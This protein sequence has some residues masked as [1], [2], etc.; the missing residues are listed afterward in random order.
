[1]NTFS[2][3]S[4]LVFA[5]ALAVCALGLP[6]VASAS[7]WGPVG[8]ADHVLNTPNFGFLSNFLGQPATSSCTSSSF[9]AVVLSAADMQ[10]RAGSF[11]GLCTFTGA[12]VGTCTMT[13]TPTRLPWTATAVTTSNIQIHGVHIDVRFEQP[14]NGL[15]SCAN[16]NG[17]DLTFTG[18]IT[19]VR[20]LGPGRIDLGGAHG[21]VSHSALGNNNPISAQGLLSDASATPI[22]VTG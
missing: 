14:R 8:G 20:Y 1:M 10:I 17:A 13:M 22:T 21:L 2:K 18:T 11:G 7:S 3:K 5:G 16:V 6:A 12:S 15:N 19:N 9:T 4:V